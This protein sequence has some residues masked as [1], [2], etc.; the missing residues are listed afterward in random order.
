MKRRLLILG[1][2][3][4]LPALAQ[5]TRQTGRPIYRCGNE[6]S[7]RPCAP[8]ASA[9]AGP[10][11]DQPS[12]DDTEAARRR[13]AAEAKQARALQQ[14]RERFEKQAPAAPVSL[15]GATGTGQKRG[16]AKARAERKASTP[17]HKPGATP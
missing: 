3:A 11:F 17:P 16:K 13:S 12:S 7:D 4:S 2:A 8:A 9:S 6:I 10:A 14:Q 1:A 5:T 15:S